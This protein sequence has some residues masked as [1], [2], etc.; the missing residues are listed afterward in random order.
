MTKEEYEARLNAIY[1]KE[2]S[3]YPQNDYILD[4]IKS[5]LRTGSAKQL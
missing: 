5:V 1:P 4:E 3:I 2:K